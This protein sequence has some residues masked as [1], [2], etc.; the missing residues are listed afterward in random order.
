MWPQRDSPCSGESLYPDTQCLLSIARDVRYWGRT[1][2]LHC[3]SPC[4]LFQEPQPDPKNCWRSTMFLA[5]LAKNPTSGPWLHL[6]LTSYIQ[7]VSKSYWLCRPKSYLNL[8]SYLA[9]SCLNLATVIS[10]LGDISSPFTGLQP[11]PLPSCSPSSSQR[12]P[13]ETEIRSCH[14]LH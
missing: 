8:S 13:L 10:C 1:S 5:A 7:A 12:G 14:P 3:L 9:S 11:R 2:H 6:V 4:W